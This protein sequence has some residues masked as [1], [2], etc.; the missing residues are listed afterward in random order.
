M[1]PLL[2]QILTWITGISM[3]VAILATIALIAIRALLNED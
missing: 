1:G 2:F 3:A